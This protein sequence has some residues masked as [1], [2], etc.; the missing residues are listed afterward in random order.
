MMCDWFFQSHKPK[1][2]ENN[3]E[4]DTSHD[5]TDAVSAMNLNKCTTD[6]GHLQGKNCQQGFTSQDKSI[7]IRNDDFG[8]V[9]DKYI[10]TWT[11][12]IRDMVNSGHIEHAAI[13]DINGNLLASS[14]TD[15]NIDPSDLHCLISGISKPALLRSTGFKVYDT[16]YRHYLDDGQLGLMGKNADG[17]G[18]S[19]SRSFKLLI[20]ATNNT[21]MNAAICNEIVMMLADFFIQKAL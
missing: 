13:H 21:N 8:G 2:R 19:V 5:I 14:S 17:S 3:Y 15:F 10:T 6:H 18:C 11:S 16:T 12:Y 4:K 20:I 9:R 1:R 7:S